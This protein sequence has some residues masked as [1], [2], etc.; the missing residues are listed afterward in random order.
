MAE[1]TPYCARCVMIF[2]DVYYDYLKDDIRHEIHENCQACYRG[3]ILKLRPG[4]NH[5]CKQYENNFLLAYEKFGDKVMKKIAKNKWSKI[6]I[7]EKHD[8]RRN[9]WGDSYRGPHSKKCNL[10][11]DYYI[12]NLWNI[13]HLLAR[14]KKRVK[15]GSNYFPVE[16]KCSDCYNRRSL[17]TKAYYNDNW[18]GYDTDELEDLYD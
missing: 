4:K 6:I 16:K 2:V 11:M 7:G 5:T 13:P 14:I 1:S 9:F 17:L 12:E 10:S 8:D 18:E 15:E 3:K